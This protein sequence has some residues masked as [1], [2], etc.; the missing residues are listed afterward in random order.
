[1]L[2]KSTN[3]DKGRMFK[4][5]KVIYNTKNGRLYSMFLAYTSKYGKCSMKI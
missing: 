5:P 3:I 1:M 2:W 4:L